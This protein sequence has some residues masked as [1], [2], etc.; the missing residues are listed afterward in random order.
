MN[1]GLGEAGNA[2]RVEEPTAVAEDEAPAGG[3]EGPGA[4]G[5]APGAAAHDAAGDPPDA[6]AGDAPSFTDDGRPAED[7]GAL[8]DALAAARGR[9][10]AR[11]TEPSPSTAPRSTIGPSQANGVAWMPR[12][13]G[14]G[15]PS[16]A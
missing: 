15:T 1:Q 14:C 8:A 13:I 6:K 7:D 11:M 4:A 2:G 3:G 10:V 5:D 16:S 9:L 12:E